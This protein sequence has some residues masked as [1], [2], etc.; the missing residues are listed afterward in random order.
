[1]KLLLALALVGVA[2][3]ERLSSPTFDSFMAT[4]GF[5]YPPPISKVYESEVE[6]NVRYW[7]FFKN[8]AKWEL[9][10][11]SE[12]GTAT[13]GPTQ[14]ADLSEEEFK[15]QYLSPVTSKDMFYLGMMPKAAELDTTKMADSVDWVAK[16][17]VT[18]V[19]NQGMCG[20]LPN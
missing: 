3:S 1:M 9:L 12:Q 8:M 15:A 20:S 13:Y 16:G 7:T 10:Q 2:L 17:A 11:K 4:H 6:H 14:F 5:Y 18:E 19:K